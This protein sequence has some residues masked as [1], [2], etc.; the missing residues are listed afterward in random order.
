MTSIRIR[1]RGKGNELQGDGLAEDEARS[2]GRAHRSPLWR[3]RVQRLR[4]SK[5]GAEAARRALFASMR[6][7]R[8]QARGRVCVGGGLARVGTGAGEQARWVKA[9]MACP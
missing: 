2:S 4:A 8:E 9:P 6:R 3:G 7:R 1:V 5:V